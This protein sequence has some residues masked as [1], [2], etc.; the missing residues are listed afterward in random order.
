YYIRMMAT[1]ELDGKSL[2]K[3]FIIPVRVGDSTFELEP[4]G[5]VVTD[6][7]GQTLIIQKADG[8]K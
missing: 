8:E 5:E 7:K 2:S 4:V 1:I 6:E 3:P